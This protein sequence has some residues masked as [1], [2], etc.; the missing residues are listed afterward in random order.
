MGPGAGLPSGF[1]EAPTP[2]TGVGS[3]AWMIHPPQKKRV[4]HTKDLIMYL[5]IWKAVTLSTYHQVHKS[6]QVF[7]GYMMCTGGEN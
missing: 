3:I 4:E 2:K 1:T 6:I 5:Q 7:I